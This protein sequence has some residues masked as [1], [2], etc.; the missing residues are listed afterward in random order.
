[1]LGEVSLEQ[2]LYDSTGISGVFKI[3]LTENRMVAV[4]GL[5]ERGKG[6]VQL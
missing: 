1:M 5:G 4:R 6:T 2:T 3:I